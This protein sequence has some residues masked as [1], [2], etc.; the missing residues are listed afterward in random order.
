[1]AQPEFLGEFVTL[2]AR[3]G[4]PVGV[5]T[6]GHWDWSAVQGVI[7]QLDFIFYDIKCIDAELHRQITGQGNDLILDNLHRLAQ[8]RRTQTIISVPVVPG[9]NSRLQ[10]FEGIAAICRNLG[11]R[12]VRLLPYH[13]FGAEKY[14]ELGRAYQLDHVHAPS[15]ENLEEMMAGFVAQDLDCRIE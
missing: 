8:I 1:M 13:S 3:R 14:R 4:V 7:E 6:C 9:V 12:A 11:I 2:C 10:E 15:R 5:E